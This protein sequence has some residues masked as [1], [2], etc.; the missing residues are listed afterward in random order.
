MLSHRT[1]SLLS[2][3]FQINPLLYWVLFR[4]NSN[5]KNSIGLQAKRCLITLAGWALPVLY[6][7]LSLACCI[8]QAEPCLFYMAGSAGPC[9]EFSAIALYASVFN[10][11]TLF[12]LTVALYELTSLSPAPPATTAMPSHAPPADPGWGRQ[13][14]SRRSD[15]SANPPGKSSSLGIIV[16]ANHRN[17]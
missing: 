2:Y 14:C 16:F 15:N 3:A 8:W 12:C 7:R 5:I 6:G 17:S 1:L 11:V 10:D 4:G 13:G 9:L